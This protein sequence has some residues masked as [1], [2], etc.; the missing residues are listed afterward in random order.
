[1]AHRPAD[2]TSRGRAQ[3]FC[4]R[5]GLAA[6]ILEGPMAGACPPRRAAAI[7]GAGGMG[8]MGARFD[9]APAIAAW[10]AA[11]RK[12]G[13]GPL[14]LN[15]W[16]P[17]PEPTRD[18]AAE[19]RL[20]DFLAGWGPAPG[21]FKPP[22]AGQFEAQLEAFLEARP[23]AVSSIM[24][25]LPQAYVARLKA[26]GI[27]W[28]C[29][30]TT[31]AEAR[32]AQAAGADVIVAQGMEAGG[33][34]GAFDAALAERQSVG[35]MALIP[36]LADAIDLPIVAA[37]AI[38][39]GRAA[40]AALTLGA[41]A[42]QIGTAFLRCPESE[43]VPAWSQALAGLEPEATVPTR[44]FT[45]RLGRGVETDYVRA[46]QAADAPPIAPFPVQSAITA[47]MRDAAKAAGDPSRMQ[48]WAG[49]AAA[50]ARAEPAAAVVTRVW[51]EAQGLLA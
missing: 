51:G 17:D 39:D 16:V 32:Q 40:A 42:V 12:A 23:T 13:G 36:R 8:G 31:L 26:A 6:P 20:R 30:V 46:A 33:H 41:S 21:E 11:F 15:T 44:A 27:A 3:A 7:A 29:N 1:M 43:L 47:P 34:R 14:Q 4:A 19:A 45:G 22:A 49:Q 25:L 10:V 2:L 35:L 9:G 38:A 5:Y 50:L 37:G 24:G 18:L 48:M 28:F